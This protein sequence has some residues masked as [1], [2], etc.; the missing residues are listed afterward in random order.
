MRTVEPTQMRTVEL[1]V[2]SQES[3]STFGGQTAFSDLPILLAV[4]RSRK[5]TLVEARA[6]SQIVRT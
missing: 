2:S 6:L 1:L 5:I 3:G 4:S